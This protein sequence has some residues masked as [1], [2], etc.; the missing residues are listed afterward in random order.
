[1][2]SNIFIPKRINVG[3]NK[4]ADTYTQKLA[5]VIYWDE[6]GK[7]RK[8]TSWEGWRDKDIPPEA[9]DN[10][11][12]SG[13]V[14]NKNVGGYAYHWDARKAYIRIYDPR[15]FEFEITLPNL[16]YILENTNCIK[17]KGLEGEF[18]YGWDGKDLVLVPVNAPEYKAMEE[19][20]SLVFDTKPL[21][22]KDMK[23]G[24]TY[25]TAKNERYVYMGKG[26]KWGCE[27]S[28]YHWWGYS[29][30]SNAKEFKAQYPDAVREPTSPYLQYVINKHSDKQKHWFIE[31]RDG[32]AYI[33]DFAS[34][35]RK[36]YSCEGVHK[37]YH[38]F[39]EA[40][41][42]YSDYMPIDY[43]QYQYVP[44]IRIEFMEKFTNEMVQAKHRGYTTT[45]YIDFVGTDGYLRRGELKVNGQQE[46]FRWYIH[47]V[48]YPAYNDYNKT[49]ETITLEELYEKYTPVKTKL[50][51]LN[52]KEY[53]CK[54]G[55]VDGYEE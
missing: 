14:L 44:L 35:P 42:S 38:I 3:F 48:E 54:W 11:P 20:T 13:F 37:D 36:F 30:G 25:L 5:Y 55:R 4:R 34:I 10:T 16:L 19:M 18:V 24:H 23:I 1:M 8:E 50:F 21:G 47:P 12:T 29:R 51:L 41:E 39:N 46:V 53:E 26:Y 22:A 52:G 43:T 40:L 33:V 49:F 17:G 6:K 32:K 7:L 27:R 45:E 28:Y 2:T 15:G 9:Y 31:L